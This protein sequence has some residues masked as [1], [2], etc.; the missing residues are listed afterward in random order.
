MIEKTTLMILN[1]T[2][3]YI[4][5]VCWTKQFTLGTFFNEANEIAEWF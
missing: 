5:Q 4:E 2:L 1:G 3:K